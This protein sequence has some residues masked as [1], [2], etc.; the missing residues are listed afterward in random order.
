[1]LCLDS[2]LPLALNREDGLIVGSTVT[3]SEKLFATPISLAD[4]ACLVEWAFRSELLFILHCWKDETFGL[5]A[6]LL[7]TLWNCFDSNLGLS[8]FWTDLKSSFDFDLHLKSEKLFN[9]C[10]TGSKHVGLRRLIWNSLS[11]EVYSLKSL[12][13]WVCKT[14]AHRTGFALCFGVFWS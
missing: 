2:S 12:K 1:M 11:K 14:L 13:R 10:E 6:T 9:Y 7:G 3:N 4:P 5:W 8:L